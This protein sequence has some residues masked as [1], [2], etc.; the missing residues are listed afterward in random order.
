MTD[1][2]IA[3]LDVHA[4]ENEVSRLPEVVACRIVPDSLGDPIEVHV[5]AHSGKHPKQVVRD[6]QSVAMASFGVDIDRRIV[7]VVQLSPEGDSSTEIGGSNIRPVVGAIQSQIEGRKAAFRVT[8]S[9]GSADATGFAEGSIAG[10]TRLRLVASA[11]LD[12]IRQL[13]EE[14]VS[15]ELD[16]AASTRVGSKDVVVVTIVRVDPPDES[17]F[18]GSAVPHGSADVATVYAALDAVDHALPGVAGSPTI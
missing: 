15:L 6:I 18:A 11:T 7:S 16:E 9:S 8:L 3:G 14:A 10:A 12:A 1:Q 2:G 4:I 13:H 5:L 17:E